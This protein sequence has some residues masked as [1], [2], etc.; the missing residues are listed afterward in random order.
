[1]REKLIMAMSKN[2]PN[3]KKKTSVCYKKGSC[4]G[5]CAQFVLTMMELEDRERIMLSR[6]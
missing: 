6:K 2:C 1:M 4:D 3:M 5:H